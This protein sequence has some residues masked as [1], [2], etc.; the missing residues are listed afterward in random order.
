MKGKL[1]SLSKDEAEKAAKETVDSHKKI[2]KRILNAVIIINILI[3][4]SIFITPLY[5]FPH[6]AELWF[7]IPIMLLLVFFLFKTTDYQ[8]YLNEKIVILS[9]DKVTYMEKLNLL[10][11]FENEPKIT[12]LK[13]MKIFFDL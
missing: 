12:F 1:T 7:H 11:K 2:Y 4:I 8:Q 9:Y 3:M 5:M 10:N 6:E 13:R